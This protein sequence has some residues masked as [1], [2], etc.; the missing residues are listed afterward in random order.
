MIYVK[1]LYMSRPDDLNY[2]LPKSI[3]KSIKKVDIK[4]IDS[5]LD[6]MWSFV[7]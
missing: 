2:I 4:L 3:V 6:E 5:E 1:E 7:G